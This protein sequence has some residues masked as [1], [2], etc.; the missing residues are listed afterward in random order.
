MNFTLSKMYEIYVCVCVCVRIYT[1]IFYLKRFETP[2]EMT[3]YFFP[4]VT[5]VEKALVENVEK[6]IS[7]SL[8]ESHHFPSGMPSFVFSNS[9]P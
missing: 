3:L 8:V 4:L 5:N 9:L 1:N 2:Q 7:F 6:Q